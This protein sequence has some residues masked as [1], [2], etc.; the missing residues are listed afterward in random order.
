MGGNTKQTTHTAEYTTMQSDIDIAT[1]TTSLTASAHHPLSP[2][3]EINDATNSAA[4]EDDTN[5]HE[6]DLFLPKINVCIPSGAFG[7][8]LGAFIDRF[9]SDRYF[10]TDTEVWMPPSVA[11]Q[12]WSWGGITPEIK[13]E[14]EGMLK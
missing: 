5:H 2:P 13:S 6:Q 8:A 3:S 14:I 9:E 4:S 11:R 10:I 7:N 12:F 1:A